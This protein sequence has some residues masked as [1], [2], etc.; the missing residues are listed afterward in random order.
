MQMHPTRKTPI[1]VLPG[2]YLAPSMRLTP[3]GRAEYYDVK[4][5]K[6]TVRAL[7][8]TQWPSA[9]DS[10]FETRRSVRVALVYTP[11][12]DGSPTVIELNESA[13]VKKARPH[14]L[15]LQLE[16]RIRD[17]AGEYI[18]LDYYDVMGQRLTARAFEQLT[19]SSTGFETTV[20]AYAQT[21]PRYAFSRLL[22]AIQEPSPEKFVWY[23]FGNLR[24]EG[25]R[26]LRNWPMAYADA[27]A[28]AWT[29][30]LKCSGRDGVVVR[31]D[32]ATA[33][34]VAPPWPCRAIVELRRV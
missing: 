4:S 1:R 5:R 16:P 7:A 11:A 3:D 21:Q 15:Q 25:F 8:A 31:I 17:I 29:V 32:E 2:G 30:T 28:G 13:R 14:G 24:F 9:F 33:A 20:Y 19:G 10:A 6:Y 18:S 23:Y 26:T 34:R 12:E 27:D 22:L